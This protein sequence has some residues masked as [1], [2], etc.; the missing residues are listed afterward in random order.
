MK[1]KENG[2]MEEAEGGR[3]MVDAKMSGGRKER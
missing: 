2:W 3:R 1:M